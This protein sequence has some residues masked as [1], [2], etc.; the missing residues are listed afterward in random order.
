MT[1]KFSAQFCLDLDEALAHY[2]AI[3][4]ELAAGFL[5]E[6]ETMQGHLRLFPD[7]SPLTSFPPIRKFL[8]KRFPFRVRYSHEGELIIFLTLENMRQDLPL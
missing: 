3:D 4:Q 1:F 2:L 8:F 6:I 7:A 5:D